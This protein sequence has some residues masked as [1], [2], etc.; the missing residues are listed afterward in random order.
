M[1]AILFFGPLRCAYTDRFEDAANQVKVVSAIIGKHK[2]VEYRARLTQNQT[3]ETLD[4]LVTMILHT[5]GKARLD[6]GPQQITEFTYG[7]VRRGLLFTDVVKETTTYC[8][9]S[10]DDDIEVA[11]TNLWLTTSFLSS[12][13]EQVDLY[14]T[15]THS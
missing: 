1:A 8:D 6:Y 13:V 11:I 12:T 2:R 7:L 3:L 10:F 14:A 4:T 5:S 15:L 9:C